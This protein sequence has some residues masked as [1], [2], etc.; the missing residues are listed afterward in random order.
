MGGHRAG[1]RMF[2]TIPVLLGAFLGLTTFIV[3]QQESA[4][5]RALP[6]IKQLFNDLQE[7]QKQIESLMEQYGCTEDEELHEL[8][9]NGRVKKSIVNQY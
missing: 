4:P 8:D 2:Q 5:R 7:N 9:K 6:D 1:C 3:G